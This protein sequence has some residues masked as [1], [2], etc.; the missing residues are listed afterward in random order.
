MARMTNPI[1]AKCPACGAA[2]GVPCY[3]IR[4]GRKRVPVP[5]SGHHLT[6]AGAA[7]HQAHTEGLRA[8]S[9]VAPP[10]RI[11]AKD[12]PGV[13]KGRSLSRDQLERMGE[14]LRILGHSDY[15][16][17]KRG[18]WWQHFSTSVATPYRNCYVC[19]RTGS[20]LHHTDY[21][22]LGR[23][24]ADDVVPLCR[25]HHVATHRV[26]YGERRPLVSAHITVRE[27]HERGESLTRSRQCSPAA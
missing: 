20:D 14:R 22:T 15:T 6:R 2:P 19:G 27:R 26:H 3:P 16:S 8:A 4:R 10:R 12:E 5:A 1:S 18:A 17:Y 21:S 7:E 24:R 13:K 11:K 23:E 9:V 25:E